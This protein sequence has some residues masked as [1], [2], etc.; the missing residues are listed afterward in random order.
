MLAS[1]WTYGVMD[2]PQNLLV[3][4]L[5]FALANQ[6]LWHACGGS[7]W[8]CMYSC[9]VCLGFRQALAKRSLLASAPG[10]KDGPKIRVP[11]MAAAF[12]VSKNA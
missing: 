12:K 2:S 7:D 6:F 10:S 5:V 4:V 3:H 1:A 11:A 8:S 9:G